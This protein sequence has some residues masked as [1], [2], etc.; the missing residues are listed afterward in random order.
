MN[1]VNNIKTL[2]D[3]SDYRVSDIM[4]K[5]GPRWEQSGNMVLK[6]EKYKG[7]IL[8]EYLQINGLY[9]IPNLNL[10]LKI[11][12][13]HNSDNNLPIPQDDEIVIHLRLGDVIFH[14][15]FLTKNYIEEI[16]NILKKN[17]NINK[18]TFVCCFSYQV[19]SK[20]SLYLRKED[21]P[22]WDEPLW[23]YTEED[24]N[25]NI[26]KT[27]IL[28]NNI[29]NFFPNMEIKVYSN[30][31]I[32]SDICYCSLSKNFIHD[33]GGFSKLML[34]LNNLKNSI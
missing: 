24:Q 9:N 25:K 7:T 34:D 15:W 16:N 22:L 33:R 21:D 4:F 13:K 29:V 30:I 18:I 28:F 27:K 10:L 3:N 19:W 2:K 5:L 23:E 32:D 17:N 20:D 14:T 26:E 1:L 12:E 11:I 6:D 31:N 8:R